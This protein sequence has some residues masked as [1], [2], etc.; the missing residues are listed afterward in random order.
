MAGGVSSD[1]PV[2]ITVALDGRVIIK[3]VERAVRDREL[4]LQAKDI[5]S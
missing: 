3:R 4:I 1:V 5:A 2:I